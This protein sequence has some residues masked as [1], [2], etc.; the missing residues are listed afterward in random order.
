MYDFLKKQETFHETRR[1]VCEYL[2]LVE[3]GRH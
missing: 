1:A 2:E 3:F